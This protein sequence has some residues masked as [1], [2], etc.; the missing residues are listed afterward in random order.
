M[1]WIAAFRRTALT[2]V[3]F[4]AASALHAQSVPKLAIVNLRLAIATT[5]EGKQALADFETRF[6]SRQKELDEINRKIDDIA[7]QFGEK[8]NTWSDEQKAKAQL[9]GQRLTRLLN[10]KQADYK[11]DRDAAKDDIVQRIGVK[12]IP[13]IDRYAQENNLGTVIDSSAP[14][15]PLLFVSPTVDI[16]EAVAKLYDQTYPVKAAVAAPAKPAAPA[17]RPAASPAKP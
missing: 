11:A 1:N 3:C 16:T 5:G 10:R 15:T 17:T 7:R 4:L 6:A 12:L 13:L 9:E 8:Q 2:L 14:G